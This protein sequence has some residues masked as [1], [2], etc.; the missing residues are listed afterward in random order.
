MQKI[1]LHER[2]PGQPLA[3]QERERRLAAAIVA[4]NPDGTDFFTDEEL[5]ALAFE[6]HRGYN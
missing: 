1:E 3:E 4:T 6:V 2:Y 5:E